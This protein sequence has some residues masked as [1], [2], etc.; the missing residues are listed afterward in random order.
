M[1]R[2]PRANGWQE[3]S[4][5]GSLEGSGRMASWAKAAMCLIPKGKEVYFEAE[6]GEWIAFYLFRPSGSLEH[7]PTPSCARQDEWATTQSRSG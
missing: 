4:S 1:G 6:F 2:K 5:A 7:A 3:F